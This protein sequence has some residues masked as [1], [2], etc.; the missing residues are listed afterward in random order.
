LAC[1]HLISGEYPPQL[2]GVSDY[3][4]MVARGLAAVGDCVQV[5]APGAARPLARDPGVEVHPLPDH[6]GPHSL[7]ILSRGLARE[8]EML[9]QYV[10]HAF[11]FKAMN[12]PFCAWLLMRRREAVTVVFHEVA[13]PLRR[14]QPLRHNVL[15]VVTR[16]MALMVARSARRI[17]VTVPGC[18]R[19]LQPMVSAR[20]AIGWLPVPSTIPVIDDREGIRAVRLRYA[21]A[22]GGL[23]IGHFG[24]YGEWISNM[25]LA[26]LPAVL[27]EYPQ[28]VALLMGANSEKFRAVMLR[29]Y[30]QLAA[31][32][33][34]TGPLAA[35]DT[36]RHIAACDLMVQPYQDGI[37][38]RRTSAMAGLS[39]GRPVVTT[40]GEATEAL[41][42]ESGAV[43]MA[44]AGDAAEFAKVAGM[45]LGGEARR[46]Y[47]AEAGRR[48]YQQQF[49]L[50][51]TIAA[52]RHA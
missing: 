43:A 23:L 36:S 6:F 9:V 31:R 44:E 15:G 21:F 40:R 8:G 16:V 47:L 11:G 52:L 39:H 51:H 48:L 38:G 33:H 24:T 35:S 10:P 1:W 12:L 22:D 18:I 42:S 30:P 46:E 20:L 14:R 7:A 27:G 50:R 45:M 37:S 3:T 19:L 5:W 41:W 2:G 29:E 28:A 25:L 13:F 49:D 4:R 34:A 32:F 26:S 17:F